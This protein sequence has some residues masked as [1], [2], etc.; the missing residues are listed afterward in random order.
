MSFTTTPTP[1]L[2]IVLSDI[3]L[4]V[5][6]NILVPVLRSDNFL[7]SDYFNTLLEAAK[8]NFFFDS[9]LILRVFLK[10]SNVLILCL[11]PNEEP[12]FLSML[13]TG[14]IESK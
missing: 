7:L 3:F 4:R 10:N 11:N 14:L 8:D 6:S 9:P 1:M 13:Y 12:A 2:D 5:I